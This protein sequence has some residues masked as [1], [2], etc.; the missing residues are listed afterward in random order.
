MEVTNYLDHGSQ[1]AV[2]F[3]EGAL[4]IC[5]AGIVGI[6]MGTIRSGKIMLKKVRF[7]RLENPRKTTLFSPD[8]RE[9]F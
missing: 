7:G 8:A 6:P 4:S 2:V 5:W 3:Y 1:N 9:F